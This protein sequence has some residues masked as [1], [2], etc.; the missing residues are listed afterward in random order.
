MRPSPKRTE[1]VR[2]G[3]G[4]G[5]ATTLTISPEAVRARWP[6]ASQ[7][8][9]AGA[10]HIGG[11]TVRQ[12][13]G[14]ERQGGA[15]GGP[16]AGGGTKAEAGASAAP[17]PQVPSGRIPAGDRPGGGRRPGTGSACPARRG[18]PDTRGTVG[19]GTQGTGDEPRVARAHCG[20][21]SA[22][23]NTLHRLLV[24]GLR[25]GPAGDGA[26]GAGAPA[27]QPPASA[28]GAI[29]GDW[30]GGARGAAPPA[31]QS[32]A[33]ACRPTGETC[34]PCVLEASR[35]ASMRGG[36]LPRLSVEMAR[37]AAAGSM[38][39]AAGSAA[40]PAGGESCSA[41][42][43]A[44]LAMTSCTT[45]VMVRPRAERLLARKRVETMPESPASRT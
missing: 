28:P 22:G 45:S 44:P 15:C 20:P 35:S 5:P 42:S 31:V 32:P 4:W 41:V 25:G 14:V 1:Y 10:S 18:D 24:D 19:P 37:P 27:V 6:R 40:S 33:S 11:G 7:T 9:G 29:N 23:R 21:R 16:G 30:L 17:R 36:R 13:R 3:P 34:S 8:D 2:A 12:R 39:V 43:T 38:A 26:R